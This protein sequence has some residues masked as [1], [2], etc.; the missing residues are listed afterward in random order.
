MFHLIRVTLLLIPVRS[1]L[2]HPFVTTLLIGI[3]SVHRT[4]TLF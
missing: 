4:R 3:H 2:F 1:F